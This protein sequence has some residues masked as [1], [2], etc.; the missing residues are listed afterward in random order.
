MK[1]KIIRND[2]SRIENGVRK[3]LGDI[4]DITKEELRGGGYAPLNINVKRKH[5][6]KPSTKEDIPSHGDTKNSNE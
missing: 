4:V 1:A 3:G 5:D 2:V 6:I